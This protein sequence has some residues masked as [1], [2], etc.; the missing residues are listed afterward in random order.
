[1]GVTTEMQLYGSGRCNNMKYIITFL[2]VLFA[3]SC[4]QEQHP[5]YEPITNNLPPDGK[6]IVYDPDSSFTNIEA[7][8]RELSVEQ[9]Q[10]FNKSLEWYGTEASLGL[11]RLH[12][13]T[14]KETVDIV[15]C[16]KVTKPDNAE[17][18]LK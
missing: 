13:R 8:S 6:T 1:M 3:T 11:D 10:T 15:N 16:L 9:A 14:A 12:G 17:N 7:I 4:S 5:S 18:C 2:F